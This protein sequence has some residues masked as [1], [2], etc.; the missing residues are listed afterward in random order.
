[1]TRMP[2]R[3]KGKLSAF[4]NKN[5][6]IINT[7]QNRRLIYMWQCTG[8]NGSL[9]SFARILKSIIMKQNWRKTI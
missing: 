2:N 3:L 5:T 8:R 1:M 7:K 4:E 9:I 6:R